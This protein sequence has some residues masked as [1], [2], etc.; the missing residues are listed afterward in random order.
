VHAAQ[1]AGW[2]TCL[3]LSPTAASWWEGR[4]PEL[5]ELTGHPVR[6]RYT[7]PGEQG[8]LPLADAMLGL[9]S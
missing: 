9:Q 4:L 7:R 3:I 1:S 5:E 2:D 8:G 6:A